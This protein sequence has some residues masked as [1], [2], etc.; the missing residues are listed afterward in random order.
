VR[1]NDSFIIGAGGVVGSIVGSRLALGIEGRTL[2][3]LF[4]FLVLFVAVRTLYR[5]LRDAAA[6]A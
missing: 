3:L 6:R 2:S 4:G 5:T 1:L